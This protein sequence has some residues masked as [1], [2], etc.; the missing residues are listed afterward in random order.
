MTHHFIIIYNSIVEKKRRLQSLHLKM[1][2]SVKREFFNKCVKQGA[3]H[4]FLKIDNYKN[5]KLHILFT[6][7]KTKEKLIFFSVVARRAIIP[8]K[9]GVIN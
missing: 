2:K 4:I 9:S 8:D 6:V 7:K 3:P 1:K 5:K